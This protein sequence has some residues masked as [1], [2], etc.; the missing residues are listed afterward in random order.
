MKDKFFVAMNKMLDRWKKVGEERTICGKKVRFLPRLISITL[1][2]IDSVDITAEDGGLTTS[3]NTCF[4]QKASIRV[5]VAIGDSNG[6]GI[7]TLRAAVPSQSIDGLKQKM[8]ERLDDGYKEALAEYFEHHED[9]SRHQ[10]PWIFKKLSSEEPVDYK[11][12]EKEFNLDTKKLSL[13]IEEASKLLQSLKEVEASD[14]DAEFWRENRRFARFERYSRKYLRSNI[15]TS[16]VWGSI[17]FRVNMR[18][19]NGR[20]VDYGER[21]ASVH[22]KDFTKENILDTAKKL[23]KVVKEMAGAKVQRSGCFKMIF[24]SKANGV[25]IHEGGPGHL[26]SGKYI[27]ELEATTYT[28]ENIGQKVFP[29]FITLWDDPTLAGGFGSYKFDEE[30]VPAQRTLIVENGILK[31]FLHDR[32]SAGR[33]GIKSNGKARAYKTRKSEPRITNLIEEA[34]K[35]YSME[36]LVKKMRR[37]LKRDGEEYGLLIK[38][39][40]GDVYPETGEYRRYPNTAYRIYADGRME[41]VSSFIIYQEPHQSFKNTV[42]LGK[43]QEICYGFCGAESGLIPVQETCPSAYVKSVE[44]H[45]LG[46]KIPRERLLKKLELEEKKDYYDEDDD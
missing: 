10:G 7:D 29:D 30:G 45:T 2:H 11:E 37:D 22:L 17:K 5:R 21:L 46:E 1:K 18:D 15:F 32:I 25:G 24:D 9:I 40:G 23:A 42:A 4:K 8:E 43:E 20:L 44:V 19:A 38:G 33:E 26:F 6:V 14:I 31:T 35:F 39:G 12:R 28:K 34:S 3:P 13:W 41:P 27:Y 36:G 16:Q